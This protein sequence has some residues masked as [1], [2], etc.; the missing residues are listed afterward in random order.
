V[1]EKVQAKL[2]WEPAVPDRE[3]ERFL[4]DFYTAQRRRLE[5]KMMLGHRQ[6]RKRATA[7]RRP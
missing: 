3:V 4:H 6:E 7:T 1:A 2:R 5:Q